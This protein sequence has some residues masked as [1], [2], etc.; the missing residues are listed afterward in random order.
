MIT[1]KNVAVFFF[2]KISEKFAVDEIMRIF[3]I[4]K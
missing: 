1:I 3:V 2:K 4:Q